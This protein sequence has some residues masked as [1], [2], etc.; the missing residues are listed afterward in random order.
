MTA[1]RATEDAQLTEA[2]RGG[3]SQDRRIGAAA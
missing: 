2:Y 1:S 3:P